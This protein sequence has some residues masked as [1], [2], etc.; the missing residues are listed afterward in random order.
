ML[1][2]RQR[3]SYK[4]RMKTLPRIGG[5]YFAARLG[6]LLLSSLITPLLPAPAQA[7]CEH[8]DVSGQWSIQQTDGKH[9]DLS[10][11]RQDESNFKGTAAV[12]TTKSTLF[13]LVVNGYTANGNITFVINWANGTYFYH[14]GK[15][16]PDGRIEG[17]SVAVSKE[18]GVGD[19]K[20]PWVSSR[21]MKCADAVTAPPPQAEQGMAGISANPRVLRNGGTTTI[22]WNAGGGHPN[23]EVWVR[24]NDHDEKMLF[25]GPKGTQSVTVKPDKKYVYM[26]RDAGQQL[27]TVTVKTK[28]K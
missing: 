18:A 4:H 20:V 17:F 6:A 3:I 8:W 13:G 9:V 2:S 28:D 1:P 27:G 22:T 16:S 12:Q 15:I 11:I 7:A 21:A 26:L 19:K 5:Q 25:T 23:A 24:V 14:S 10:L